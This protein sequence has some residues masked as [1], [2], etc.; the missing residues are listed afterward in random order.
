MG[1]EGIMTRARWKAARALAT[2]LVSLLA[3]VVPFG[4]EASAANSLGVK[5]NDYN[6]D[7]ISDLI[8]ISTINFCM[9]RYAGNADG[10]FGQATFVSCAGWGSYQSLT[11]V[12]DMN[13]DGN[14]DLI[15]IGFDG[16]IARWKGNGNFGFNYAGTYGCGWENYEEFAGVGDFTRD[17]IPDLVAVR[18]SDGCI[19]RWKG[20]RAFG[21][22]YFGDYG[23]GWENYR[24]LE[25]VGD[26][27]NDGIGD[28]IGLRRSDGCA[29]SWHGNGNGGLDYSRD[30]LC[31]TATG[32]VVIGLG[33]LN[34]DGNGDVAGTNMVT[35]S[36]LTWVS[37]G[38]GNFVYTGQHFCCFGNMYLT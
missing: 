21:F 6:R 19:A 33:D 25:G 23:C 1:M 20:S 24:N 9:Y 7:G 38:G 5:R 15:G 29:A 4:S 17:G 31:G 28:L 18:R 37:D 8:G 12:G 22:N 10:T 13:G 27:N 26:I 34:R 3:V 2:F 32:D 30:H 16:C 36:M 14:G 11:A 35:T